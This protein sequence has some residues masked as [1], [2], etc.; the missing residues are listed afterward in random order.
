MPSLSLW[1]RYQIP[2]EM[3]I[4]TLLEFYQSI[5]TRLPSPAIIPPTQPNMKR[6]S[7]LVISLHDPLFHDRQMM[8]GQ[9]LAECQLALRRI[10]TVAGPAQKP[11]FLVSQADQVS[12]HGRRCAK[13]IHVHITDRLVVER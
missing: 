5:E 10:A 12:G 13:I 9:R 11:D 7:R 4:T 3:S 1:Y 6:F 8:R 2:P